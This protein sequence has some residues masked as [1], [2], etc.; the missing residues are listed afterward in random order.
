MLWRAYLY[1]FCAFLV[2]LDWGWFLIPLFSL[3]LISPT[4]I[5][6]QNVNLWNF[7]AES[8]HNGTSLYSARPALT[9]VCQLY[10]RC[11]YNEY[12][13]LLLC[14]VLQCSIIVIYRLAVKYLIRFA[15][16]VVC[17]ICNLMAVFTECPLI[18][19]PAFGKLLVSFEPLLLVHAQWC[20]S[21]MFLR[22]VIH[23]HKS[24][25][26]RQHVSAVLWAIM[27]P[28]QTTLIQR[29]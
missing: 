22:S 7:I 28:F 1:Y 15:A 20:Y 4:L 26:H 10:C 21:C 3:F 19:S 24:S 11:V 18:P 23:K 9:P 5:L 2:Y 14:K 16:V 25:Y 6:K 29:A 27:R 8:N 13:M 12:E 17:Y